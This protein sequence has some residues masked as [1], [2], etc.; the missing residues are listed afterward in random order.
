MNE[1]A[2]IEKAANTL[3]QTTG[4]ETAYQYKHLNKTNYPDGLLQII[5]QNMQWTYAIEAKATLTLTTAAILKRKTKNYTDRAIIVAEYIT[6]PMAEQLKNL[7][8]FFIDAAGNAYINEP[9]LYIFI[10]GNK[11]ARK[12]HAVRPKRLFKP[13][14]LKVIFALLHEPQMVNRPFRNIAE[15]AGVALGTVGGVFKELKEMGFCLAMGKKNR[16]IR[17]RATLIRRWV[18]AYPEQLRPTLVIDRFE[19]NQRDWWRDVNIRDYGAYWGGEVAAAKLTKYLKPERIIIYAD[20]PPGKL[21]LTKKLRKA[22][23][24]NVEILKPFWKTDQHFNNQ[25]TVPPLLIYADLM[26]T[27]DN[28]NIET[29]GI[30]YDQYLAQLD[31]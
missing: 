9:P 16:I 28:R 15:T 14:G 5:H 7:D 21:I 30:I 6:P 22:A 29:A 19:T 10:R 20:E 11:P 8:L 1:Q 13:R 27:G 2:L 25:E 12:A 31:G 18:E 3:E 26:A 17:E 4:L 24:G 23:N